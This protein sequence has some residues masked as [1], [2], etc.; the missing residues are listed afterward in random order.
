MNK[1]LVFFL[2]NFRRLKL[3]RPVVWFVLAGL[4]SLTLAA[5]RLPP[6]NV[7]FSSLYLL[8][9][10]AYSLLLNIKIDRKYLLFFSSAIAVFGL[11]QYILIPDTR[12]LA[13]L[14]WD[15]HYYR[16]LSTLLDP[17]FTGII[18]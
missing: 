18:L 8:R 11:A 3:F 12:F 16:L 14:N 17:N 5:F 2:V 9:F 6:V 1:F 13:V 4:A 7:L 15:D 10:L